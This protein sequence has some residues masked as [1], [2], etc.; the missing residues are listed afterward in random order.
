LKNLLTSSQSYSD[1]LFSFFRLLF[2][3]VI[4]NS[5]LN[6]GVYILSAAIAASLALL[7]LIMEGHRYD[8]QRLRN[9]QA[10]THP[11]PLSQFALA[12]RETNPE[13]VALFPDADIQQVMRYADFA[14]QFADGMNLL[15]T[16]H[17]IA[18]E[19][20]RVEQNNA[21]YIDVDVQTGVVVISTGHMQQVMAQTQV[22][23]PLSSDTLLTPDQAAFLSGVKA[24]AHLELAQLDPEGYVGL[25]NQSRSIV[26]IAN[27]LEEAV[28][29]VVKQVI[30]RLQKPA[31][32][33]DTRE[34][35]QFKYQQQPHIVQ[36]V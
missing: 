1:W 28:N 19:E 9:D 13:F 4:T 18:A 27:P 36:K 26:Q 31:I 25:V 33:I 8:N 6:G 24:A 32:V 15:A 11:P 29:G 34:V 20:I 22:K 7:V 21:P 3:F 10:E 16:S 17:N 12:C 2:V 14:Q 30:E 23:D 5:A 35:Q